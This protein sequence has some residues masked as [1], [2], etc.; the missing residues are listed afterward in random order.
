MSDDLHPVTNDPPPPKSQT[1]K[2]FIE[3]LVRP[4]VLSLRLFKHDITSR[5]VEIEDDFRAWVK[6]HSPN[7]WKKVRLTDCAI[8]WNAAIDAIIDQLTK[9]FL[10]DGGDSNVR[11]PSN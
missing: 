11:S 6:L 5:E 1:A 10:S 8:G 9:E 2:E 7:Y 4:L 3:G